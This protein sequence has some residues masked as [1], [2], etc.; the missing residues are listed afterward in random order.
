[1]QDA[2]TLY[3]RSAMVASALD[4]WTARYE[5]TTPDVLRRARRIAGAL[6][7][8][9]VGFA[10][11]TIILLATGQSP[12][13]VPLFLAVLAL[14]LC[15]VALRAGVSV[16]VV[17]NTDIAVNAA[18][19]FG[20]LLATGGAS[21]GFL[22][23]TPVVPALAVLIGNRRSILFWSGMAIAAIAVVVV[24][25][26][27]EFAFP[28][29]PDPSRVA[30]TKF[31][32]AIVVVGATFGIGR[33]FLADRDR[34]E[35]ALLESETLFKQAAQIAR[36]GHWS[37]D[38]TCGEYLSIS[39][40]YARIFGYTV[41]EFLKRFRI[42][43]Q[44]MQLAHPEDRAMIAEAYAKGGD[45]KL[46]Y[47]IVRA[48][49]RVRTVLE[50][51]RRALDTPDR[52]ARYGGTLQDVTE[53][54]QVERELRAAKETAV[55]ANRAKSVF[56]ANMSHEL[57]TPLNTIIGYSELLQEQVE[58]LEQA[59]LI[60]DLQKINTAGT[61]LVSL[62]TDVLDLS[63]IE[64]GKTQ[65]HVTTFAV[66]NLVEWVVATCS[67][68][69]ERNGNTLVVN[70]TDNIGEIRSDMTK[71]RQV[72][73][74]LLSNA[75]KFTE[76]GRIEMN[77]R[78]DAVDG[79]EMIVLEVRDTGIGITAEQAKIVFDAFMQVEGSATS[80]KTGSGL[81]LTITREYCQLL[82][83]ELKLSSVPGAGSVFTATLLADILGTQSAS[84]E[85]T[86]GEMVAQ[87][88]TTGDAPTA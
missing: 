88:V 74:N 55:E 37:F 64:A 42:L 13:A 48:D 62:I 9:V 85:A 68:L 16:D 56:L 60:P 67:Q 30:I 80:G 43:E 83:G 27:L 59:A 65:L 11:A 3:S 53:L 57:R 38:H 34:A 26:S 6:F 4:W 72:L 79:E 35:Q 44:D 84:T 76:D 52:H 20:M 33:L 2:D 17:A 39:E 12:V 77:A 32:I 14:L 18:V 23:A 81:G 7:L 31:P 71:V 5:S 58:D 86:V 22:I 75:A 87:A 24:L 21:V 49:G 15:G 10:L 36:L 63:R 25:T 51:Q 73:F 54:R 69:V 28:I 47:R 8:G 61:H 50:I 70:G 46:E 40:E 66:K 41:D 45:L 78:R 19:I 1:M 29:R 82:G